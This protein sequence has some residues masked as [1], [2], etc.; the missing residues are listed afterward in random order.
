MYEIEMPLV[1][2]LAEMERVGVKIDVQALE[3]LSAH[4]EKEKNEA[5]KRI[6]ALAGEEFNL[7]RPLSFQRSC[8][9]IKHRAFRRAP[10]A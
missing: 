5:T 7:I 8:L 10:N 3:T 6:F 1:S 9:K 4:L 2:V